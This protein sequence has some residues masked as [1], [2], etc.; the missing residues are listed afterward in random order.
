MKAIQMTAP[1]GPEVLQWVDIPEPV[2]TTPTQIRVRVRAAGVNPIDTKLRAR[3]LP[4]P[5]ALPAILG[6]D[7]A[8]DVVEVGTAVSRFKPGDRVWYCN[9]GLGAD[10]GNYA[11]YHVLEQDLAQAV[12]A[13]VRMQEAAAAPLVLL[14]AWEALFDR[15]RLREGQN[16]LVHAGAG[17]V[18]HV[19]IQLAKLGGARVICTVSNDEKA[20]FA[21]SLG[22][23]AVVNYN[24]GDWV[25][26][27]LDWSDGQGVDIALDTV[28]P[29][30]FKA[31]IPVVAL[32][33]DLVTLLN[34]GPVDWKQA[35]ERNLR[36]GFELM[37]TPMLYDL[38]QA[39]AHMG[40]ILRHCGEWMRT[41]KLRV[42]SCN[43]F[44][45]KQAA[46]AHH[47]I[48]QGHGMGKLVLDTD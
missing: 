17:G 4:L 39:R 48:E 12:P 32:Y 5:G 43:V 44:P 47:L 15:A 30:V 6:L 28:G 3:G 35:R 46:Q 40:E 33:G 11:Q 25:R 13:G 27:V 18:G 31:S 16:V 22:A 42:E 21:R 34:P 38:P 19:A 8:G 2:L 1:G 7:G 45:L 37:L 10:P 26:A 14:T 36:I 9:G 29:E 20:D 24:N 41:G 23:D